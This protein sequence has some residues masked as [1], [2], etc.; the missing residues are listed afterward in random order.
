MEQITDIS[1]LNGKTIKQ[2]NSKLEN[3]I[4]LFFTDNT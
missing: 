4:I 1:K 3:S 2:T